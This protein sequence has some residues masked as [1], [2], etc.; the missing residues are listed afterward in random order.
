MLAWFALFGSF[1][2]AI[3]AFVGLTWWDKLAG[4]LYLLGVLGVIVFAGRKFYLQ[5]G[6][7]E[8]EDS[9]HDLE[10]CLVVLQTQLTQAIAE[11]QSENV[12]IR[13]AIH[14]PDPNDSNTLVQATNY[15][16]GDDEQTVGR[17]FDKKSGIIGVALARKRPIAAS[18]KTDN[19]QEYLKDLEQ[20]WG[21]PKADARKRDALSMSW[22]AVPIGDPVDGILYA[23]ST[24]RDFFDDPRVLLLVSGTAIAIAKYLDLREVK[25]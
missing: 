11:G 19:L 2:A 8:K 13:V 10:G 18:R 17:K 25:K 21:Y 15:I 6:K 5:W 24:L 7:Q 4:V 12:R 1:A 20:N 22:V 3:R 23:D 14:V 16:G 9:T